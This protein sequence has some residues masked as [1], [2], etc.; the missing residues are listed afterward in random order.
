MVN[1]MGRIA[2]V[3]GGTCGIGAAVATA[4]RNAGYADAATYHGNDEAAEGS[5]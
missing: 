4:L 3:T 1:A 2:P 5:T